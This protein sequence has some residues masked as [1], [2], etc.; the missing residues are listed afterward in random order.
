MPC[1]IMAKGDIRSAGREVRGWYQ[2]GHWVACFHL[3]RLGGFDYG[4]AAQLGSRTVNMVPLPGSL[5]TVTS[6][7]IM[8]ASL[9]EI[10]RPRPVPP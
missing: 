9:R 5:T 3:S 1:R 6:P 2:L 10:E 8:R 4:G 7:P